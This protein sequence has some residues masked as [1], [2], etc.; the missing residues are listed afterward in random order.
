MS[1]FAGGELKNKIP[2]YLM[3]EV[4]SFP[5]PYISSK[6]KTMG[7]PTNPPTAFGPTSGRDHPG[8]SFPHDPVKP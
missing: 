5:G 4:H 8:D 3:W 6:C 2:V 1:V 7:G